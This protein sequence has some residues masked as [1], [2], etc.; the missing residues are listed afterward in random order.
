VI[1]FN[2]GGLDHLD[3]TAAWLKRYSLAW[4]KKK[5]WI[6][7]YLIVVISISAIAICETVYR[8]RRWS[9]RRGI[10][11]TVAAVRNFPDA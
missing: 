5:T 8:L 3:N 4:N 7:H 10:P 1:Q 9:R 11:T 6:S 2:P